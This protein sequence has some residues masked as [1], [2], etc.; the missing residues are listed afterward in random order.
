[1]PLF[2]RQQTTDK[3]QQKKTLHC[4]LSI[5]HCPLRMGRRS[6]TG[7]SQKTCHFQL[8]CFL[9]SGLIAKR[10]WTHLVRASSLF[11]IVVIC[12]ILLHWRIFYRVNS[13][14]ILLIINKLPK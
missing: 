1:L 9:L 4:Q 12:C 3:R 7:V 13:V 5:G 10:T 2:E 14:F 11:F 8:L 6:I